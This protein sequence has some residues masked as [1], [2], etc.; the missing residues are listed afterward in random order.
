VDSLTGATLTNYT[1]DNSLSLTGATTIGPLFN[2]VQL[3]TNPAMSVNTVYSI[4]A[5][6]VKDCK[7]NT[8]WCQQ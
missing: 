2:L 4:T 6:N 1:I 3:K 8:I 7:G 5:G